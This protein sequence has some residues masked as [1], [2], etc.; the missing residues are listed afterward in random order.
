MTKPR[1]AVLLSSMDVLMS[2]HGCF[3]GWE[4][5]R[6]VGWEI[7]NPPAS[8]WWVVQIRRGVYRF[9]E[10]HPL[11]G[12]LATSAAHQQTT[13]ITRRCAT[14][15]CFDWAFTDI[16]TADAYGLPEEVSKE[17]IYCNSRRSQ[18]A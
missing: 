1:G 11:R 17:L 7:K 18:A 3:V 15:T 5:N 10:A 9:F 12:R 16:R 6:C 13:R 2:V 14:A 4:T 8:Q